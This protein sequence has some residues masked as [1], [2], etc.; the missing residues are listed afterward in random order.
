MTAEVTTIYN[1]FSTELLQKVKAYS[2]TQKNVRTNLTSWN[3]ELIGTSG[4]ILL[5]DLKDE[6]LAEV[7][8]EVR[9][10]ISNIDE[11]GPLTAM[12]VLG[13]R[14][15]FIQWHNDTPHTFA[16]TVYLNEQW[17]MNW[18]GAFVYEDTGKQFITVYP[19]YNKSICFEPPVWHTTNMSNLQAPLRESLQIFCDPD[20]I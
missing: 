1:A 13:G 15:S 8:E 7:K 10:H 12:Y 11:Y 18:G 20:G 17:D 19:E 4:A 2:Y 9:K 6:L 14:F 5:Y 16:M 3:P